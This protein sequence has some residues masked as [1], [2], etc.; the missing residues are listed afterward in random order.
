VGPDGAVYG[1]AA[2][3]GLN[4]PPPNLEYRKYVPEE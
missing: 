2:D 4:G 3:A 1:K